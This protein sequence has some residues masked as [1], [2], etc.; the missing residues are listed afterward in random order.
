L[1]TRLEDLSSGQMFGDRRDPH[2]RSVLGSRDLW[3]ESLSA[4]R[5]YCTEG[6][7][8]CFFI[9]TSAT[10]GTRRLHSMHEPSWLGSLLFNNLAEN[11]M[12]R[13]YSVATIILELAGINGFSTSSHCNSWTKGTFHRDFDCVKT[14]GDHFFL[15]FLDEVAPD[16]GTVEFWR[17]SKSTGPPWTRDI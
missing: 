6:T 12:Q 4:Q 3:N 8:R 9:A 7:W 5:T 17:H 1:E 15:S 14:L 16:N 11:C 13:L 2:H 10:L